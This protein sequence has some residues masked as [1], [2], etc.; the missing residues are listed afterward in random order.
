MSVPG[1]ENTLIDAATGAPFP[2]VPAQTLLG[3]SRTLG[4]RGILVEWHRLPPDELPPHYSSVMALA[5]V[6]LRTRFPSDGEDDAVGRI[7]RSILA[8]R[9][10]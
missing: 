7:A 3:S 9:I 1:G 6:R 2:A 8:S 5:S 4:W 10:S